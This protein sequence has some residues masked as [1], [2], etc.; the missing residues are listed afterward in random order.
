MELVN[1]KSRESTC[2]LSD[3]RKK[4]D[5]YPA[6]PLA[7]DLVTQVIRGSAYYFGQLYTALKDGTYRSAAAKL[8]Q[9]SQ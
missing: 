5:C 1:Q 7:T 8:R 4:T 2:Q 9:N 6:A 3:R